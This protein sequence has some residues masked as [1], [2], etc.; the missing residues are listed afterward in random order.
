M[1]KQIKE[2]LSIM[3][4]LLVANDV[5][6]GEK[7]CASGDF[8]EH[9][10][11]FRTILEIS[12]R[13][14]IANPEKMRTDYGK[15][16]HLLQDSQHKDVQKGLNFSLVKPLLT[17]ES[18]LAEKEAL[19]LLDDP[20]LELATRDITSFSKDRELVEWELE[21]KT[22][23]RQEIIQ[24]WSATDGGVLSEAEVSRVLESIGDSNTFLKGVR[25]PCDDMLNCLKRYF[26][27][28]ESSGTKSNLAITR[29]KGGSRLS[30]SHKQQYDYV[31]QSLTLWRETVNDMYKLWYLAEQD[32]LNPDYPYVL[33]LTDQGLNRMQSAA[34]VSTA[35]HEILAR[36]KGKKASW[37]GSWVVHLGDRNVPNAFI[38]ID[39]YNQI[40]RI[41]APIVS[42][43]RR[44]DDICS[45]NADVAKYIEHNFGGAESAKRTIL[46]DFFRHGFDGSG[47]D[48]YYDAG[49]CIDGR[50]TSAWNW[51]SLVEKKSYFTIFLLTGFSGFDGR[52]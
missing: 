19:D 37:I 48:N 26:K 16:I 28:S 45:E 49:S 36:V 35:M 23:A 18:F 38:F 14:K 27:R 13:H 44:L 11:L 31:E 51:C 12:R 4:G 6:K 21:Q 5:N 32:L 50:L 40:G 46:H 2:F 30:H 41:L 24:R 47:A 22:K 9:S 39:K 7:V 42:T 43:L 34:N 20:Q 1:L 10:E 29:G 8:E 3:S 25:D 17:V 33:R 15:L 52:F